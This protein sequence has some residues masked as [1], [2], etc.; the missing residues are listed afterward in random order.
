MLIHRNQETVAQVWER[1]IRSRAM[2]QDFPTTNR[3]GAGGPW[4]LTI[5]PRN[6]W[7]RGRAYFIIK[8]FI[9][10]VACLMVAPL[11]VPLLLLVALLVYVDSPGKV[12]FTQLRTGK[13]G[14]R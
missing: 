2:V 13:G 10:V 3:P 4:Y 1:M 14:R 6:R 12:L 7:I 9:D 11:I 5:D 8:R